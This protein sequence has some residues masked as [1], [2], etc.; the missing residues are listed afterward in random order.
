MN[1]TETE[2]AESRS[3]TIIFAGG[4]T[5]GHLYPAL[6][7]A[8]HLRETEPSVRCLFLCSPR[9]IDSRILSEESAEFVVIPAQPLGM[10]PMR[11]LRFAIGWRRAVRSAREVLSREAKRCVVQVV[12]MGGFVAG[13]V[14]HAARAERLPV[15]L[16]NLDAVPGKANRWIARRSERVLD[17]ASSGAW[18]KALAIRPIVR[19]SAIAS[20]SKE[21][22]RVALGLAPE[23][24]TLF[25]TGGS[26]GARTLNDL[27]ALLARD[28]APIFQGWQ[29][30]HQTGPDADEAMQRSYDEAGIPARAVAFCRTMNLAWGA[31]DLAIARCGAGAV[32]EVWANSVPTIFLPYPFHRD[33]HQRRNAQPLANAGGAL[34]F[35]DWVDARRTASDL[36]ADLSRLLSDVNARTEMHASLQRLG[37]A[38]GASEVARILLGKSTQSRGK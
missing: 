10:H 35:R 4:G 28:H 12:A 1:S 16:V 34:I 5:G 32:A 6:A 13:P 25:I 27:M 36:Q 8:E 19:R 7:I 2:P 11:L 29:V 31:A 21:E 20:M 15:I 37:P 22:C 23:M 18:P 30:Y 38:D 3:R 14:V 33:Q 9:P 26:Q 17:A 24:P